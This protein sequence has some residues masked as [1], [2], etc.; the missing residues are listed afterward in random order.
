MRTSRPRQCHIRPR[1]DQSTKHRAVSLP[2]EEISLLARFGQPTVPSHLFFISLAEC[3]PLI[4]RG[5]GVCSNTLARQDVAMIDAA[6]LGDSGPVG[7]R[8]VE[9]D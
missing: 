9:A 7:G 1:R 5:A 3:K 4:R 6:E 2:S 8:N